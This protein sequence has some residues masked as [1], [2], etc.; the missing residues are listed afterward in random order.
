[1]HLQVIP[2]VRPIGTPRV[3]QQLTPGDDPT[4]VVHQL[5]Q[6]HELLV[7]QVHR[8]PSNDEPVPIELQLHLTD[9][10]A[11]QPPESLGSIDK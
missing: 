2:D 1:V 5:L 10:Q 3:V 6:N 9:F 8:R 11:S 4:G 7:S